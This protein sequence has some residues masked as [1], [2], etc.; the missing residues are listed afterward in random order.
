MQQTCLV[1]RAVQAAA[2]AEHSHSIMA[3]IVTRRHCWVQQQ[4]VEKAQQLL[5]YSG[6]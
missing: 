4:L 6:L 2:A 5:W 1:M 3:S